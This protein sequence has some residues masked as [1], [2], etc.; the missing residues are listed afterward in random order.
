[1]IARIVLPLLL[2]NEIQV[3]VA[4]IGVDTA[5]NEPSVRRPTSDRGPCTLF[6]VAFF[7]TFPT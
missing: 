2:L 1:M 6:G 5:E 7:C 3:A 4:K